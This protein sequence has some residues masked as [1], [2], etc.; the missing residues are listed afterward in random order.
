MAVK[1]KRHSEATI[2]GALEK[3]KS[4]GEGQV[5]RVKSDRTLEV[6][7][8]V[9]P[10]EWV[11]IQQVWINR[12]PVIIT[13]ENYD[14]L[15]VQEG[16]RPGSRFLANV[17]LKNTNDSVILD[18]PITLARDVMKFYQRYGTV[19][20]RTYELSRT[21]E[22]LETEYNVFPGDKVN[23]DL[24]KYTVYDVE[25]AINAEIERQKERDAVAD[26]DTV[27]D[28]EPKPKVRIKR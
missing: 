22:G 20:D 7:F 27:E 18:M 28:D 3:R 12:K 4:M 25:D 16:L 6:T 8:L 24:T 5:Y 1:I 21:G 2:V 10:T 15:V 17:V 19:T 26:L 11:E 14:E 13:D 9:E 23:L